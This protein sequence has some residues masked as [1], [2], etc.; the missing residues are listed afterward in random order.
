MS[1]VQLVESRLAPRLARRF[2]PTIVQ[3]VKS[4]YDFICPIHFGAVTPAHVETPTLYYAMH[5]DGLNYYALY[6]VFHRMDWSELPWPIKV[7]DEHQF[8]LEGILRV[9]DIER[10]KHLWSASIFHHDILI[11]LKADPMLSFR[12]EAGGHG[13]LTPAKA[14]I[15]K[16]TLNRMNMAMRY[17]FADGCG[18]LVSIPDHMHDWRSTYERA[19]NRNGVHCPWQWSDNQIEDAHGD[20]TA[21]LIYRDPAKLLSLATGLGLV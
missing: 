7:L 14:A 4:V 19:F 13:I 11:Q 16:G 18:E 6:A 17:P 15:G 2:A 10:G 5:T 9:F 21:G 12:I 20:A 3:E 8:D 1:N